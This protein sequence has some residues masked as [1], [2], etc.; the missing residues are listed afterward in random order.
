MGYKEYVQ[1]AIMES[2]E[3]DQL[4]DTEMDTLLDIC[5]SAESAEDL[6][7]IEEYLTEKK[8]ECGSSV[9]DK[10]DKLRNS[11]ATKAGDRAFQKTINNARK[12]GKIE[13]NM[14]YMA[15][16]D[17]KNKAFNKTIS[18]FSDGNLA[19]GA[20]ALIGAMTVTGLAIR[21]AVKK[22]GSS[23]AKQILKQMK[24]LEDQAKKIAERC[25][26]GE[27][28]A[29]EAKV[30]TKK[31]Q[32]QLTKLAAEAEK[33]SAAAVKESTDMD[34]TDIQLA[35]FESFEAGTISEEERDELLAMTEG[36]NI[37]QR[38]KGKK[39]AKE[40]KEAI[41]AAKELMSKEDYTGA[42]SKLDEA[43]AKMKE[44]KSEIIHYDD[45]V[46]DIIFGRMLA[47]ATRDLKSIL[48]G[49]ISFGVGSMV[50]GIK[51]L[52][53]R[54]QGMIDVYNEEDF[55]LKMLNAN[56]TKLVGVATAMIKKMEHLKTAISEKAASKGSDSDVKKESTDN[57]V[58]DAQLSVFAACEAGE[59][60]AEDRDELIAMLER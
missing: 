3:N 4:N 2:V 14:D 52:A 35:I 29:K 39:V 13:T 33:S 24:D 6:E 57:D 9:K 43:I 37:D 21:S 20:A 32:A 8:S 55:S 31:I 1:N 40:C 12:G 46:G 5:E 23:Q 30:E 51:E 15:T 26:K 56:K 7:A 60:S 48:V 16:N 44:F 25:K 17:N 54:I 47:N 45:T 53:D 36:T 27:I 18:A 38:K 28:S 59:I 41:S 34:V 50:V 10:I 58:V 49:L 42:S 11:A 19:A 22:S